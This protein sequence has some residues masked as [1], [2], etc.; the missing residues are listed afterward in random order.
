MLT[1][2]NEKHKNG[3]VKNISF[4]Y[5]FYNLKGKY[6]YGYGYGYGDYANGYHDVAEKK[7]FFNKLISK[8][9]K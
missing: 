9:K 2:I 7:G 5:N 8:F 1:L 4:I 3:V 6:G